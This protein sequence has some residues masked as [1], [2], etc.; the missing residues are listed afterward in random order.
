VHVV[1]KLIFGADIR[2][3]MVR[4]IADAMVGPFGFGRSPKRNPEAPAAD[5]SVIRR[6]SD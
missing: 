6:G 3:Q 2:M 4:A 1:S 5:G